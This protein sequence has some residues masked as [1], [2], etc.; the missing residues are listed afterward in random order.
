M[1]RGFNFA[2][3]SLRSST[4]L[5]AL[6]INVKS[7]CSLDHWF[8]FFLCLFRANLSRSWVETGFWLP[9]WQNFDKFRWSSKF[10][11]SRF[12]K[13]FELSVTLGAESIELK[14]SPSS[15]LYFSELTL[16][17][18]FV[19]SDL[20]KL[21]DVFYAFV[22]KPIIIVEV[23]FCFVSFMFLAKICWL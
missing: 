6:F 5:A 9:N 10:D 16:I 19:G 22:W 2:Y 3:R 11:L 15:I 20:F 12:F 23:I 1:L 13:K 18:M 21:D 14:W 4:F 7:S 17:E 8:I